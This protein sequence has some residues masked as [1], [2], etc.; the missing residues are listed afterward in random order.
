VTSAASLH[1]G[2]IGPN[3]LIRVAE[4]LRASGGMALEQQVFVAAGLERYLGAPPQAMVDEDEVARLH[5]ALCRILGEPTA[6]R[7]SRRAG[8]ATADY[9]LAHRIPRPLQAV[10]RRLPAAL[11]ARVLLHAIARHAWT[12]AGSGD[13]RWQGGAVLQFSVHGNPLCRGAIATQP[14]CSYLAA[15]VEHL[16]RQLVHPATGVTETACEALGADACRFEIRW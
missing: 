7:M 11:S 16:F 15:T 14:A 3:A 10:L 9:L 4:A 8:A 1:H 5:R 13:F 2:R 6:D 12:F